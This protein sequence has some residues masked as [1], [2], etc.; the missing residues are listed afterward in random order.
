[1]TISVTCS[2]MFHWIAYHRKRCL[3]TLDCVQTLWLITG[4][5]VVSICIC[6]LHFGV[7][8]VV[9]NER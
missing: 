5:F 2:A 4:C 1:M 8:D 7:K 3:C 9:T 6:N